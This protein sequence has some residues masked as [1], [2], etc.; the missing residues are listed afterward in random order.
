MKY[1]SLAFVLLV[2]FS[3]RQK[4]ESNKKME[5]INYID[6]ASGEH[7]TEL[8]PGE[9][10]LKWLYSS[11]TG[12]VALQILFKRKVVSTMGG[13]FM[14]SKLS[15]KRIPAFVEEHNINLAECQISDISGFP[16]FN[17]FFY[18]K[19]K[20]ESR[21]VGAHLVSPADGKILAFQ[22]INDV[23]KFFVKGSEFTI[24]SF[25]YNLKVFLNPS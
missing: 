7:K 15:A 21:P 25:F 13:W 8:V 6:R 17:Q 11:A 19:L 16:T 10:M 2:L 22:S 24:E 9:G 20:P 14:D 5:T 23:P 18:R 12:K 4:V 1:I 3:C